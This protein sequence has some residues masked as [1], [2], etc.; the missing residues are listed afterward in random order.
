MAT[1]VALVYSPSD[2]PADDV[3]IAIS[4]IDDK[5]RLLDDNY[6]AITCT[7]QIG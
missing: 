1:R 4:V 6:V 3:V 5:T 7:L 2:N